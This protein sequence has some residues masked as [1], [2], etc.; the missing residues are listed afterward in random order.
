MQTVSG[1]SE[2]HKQCRNFL[3]PYLHTQDIYRKQVPDDKVKWGVEWD[4]YRPKDYTSPQLK[5]KP[6]AD[7]QN[8][9]QCKFHT[10]D[11]GRVNR[12]SYTAEY[13]L[14]PA[15][16]RPLN[17]KGRTGLWGRGVLGRWG[18][19]HAAD[20]IVTRRTA[21][22][23]YQFVAIQRGDVSEWALPGGMVDS[24]ESGEQAAVR[25]FAEEALDKEKSPEELEPLWGRGEVIYRGYVD[26]P[27]NTDNSW[28][29]TTAINYHDE[30]GLLERVQ[31]KASSDAADV[32]WLDMAPTPKLYASHQQI[33]ES[34]AKKFNLTSTSESASKGD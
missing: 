13:D 9:R 20:A 6:Y 21:E 27:R 31:L 15:S 19:N 11:K 16:G 5:G 17:P 33:L 14:D 23:I 18:P 25:E 28:M 7:G 1:S 24:G 2:L 12:V 22:G 32:K 34:C 10:L 4:E 29:E 3:V 8:P 26:D 30:E